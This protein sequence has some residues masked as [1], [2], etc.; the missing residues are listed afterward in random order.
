MN[1]GSLA[2]LLIAGTERQMGRKASNEVYRGIFQGCGPWQGQNLYIPMTHH[3]E[4]V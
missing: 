4:L 3:T 2:R 1:D